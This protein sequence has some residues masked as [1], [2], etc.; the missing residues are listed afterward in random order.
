MPRPLVCAALALV[1]AAAPPATL[2]QAP[3]PL[4]TLTPAERAA[5]WQ[6]LFDGKSTEGWRGYRRR[7]VPVG[8]QVVDGL[9]M[10]VADGAGDMITTREFADFELELDW[11][12]APNGN[13]G[14]F[15]RGIEGDAPIYETAPEMQVLDDA[16][17]RPDGLSPLTSAGSVFGLYPTR[18][19][20][21]RPAGEW[22]HVRIVA[23]GD[24]VEHWLNGVQVATYELGS[25]DWKRR[26][27]ASKFKAWP[28]FGTARSGVIGLQDH[29]SWVAFRNIKLRELR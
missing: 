2:A 27:A 17:F 18:R 6:L 26:V 12:I 15:Y 9:L 11:N 25:P 16:R 3:A 1:A 19:G 20:V 24:H 10:R 8:W 7:N 4:N 23:R 29:G 5:G 21:V 14:I 28:R 22:N 13:S